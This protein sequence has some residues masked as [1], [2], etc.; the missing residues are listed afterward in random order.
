MGGDARPERCA[1]GED[2]R[3]EAHQNLAACPSTSPERR[4][5]HVAAAAD[6]GRD[7]AV[8]AGLE[9]AAA[10]FR[11]RRD[12]FEAAAAME[13][14]AERSPDPEAAAR[15]LA[16]AVSDARD[17][18][19]TRW[20]TD[21]HAAVR[22]TTADPDLIAA[23]A[24][25]AALALSRSGRQHAAYGLITAA[26]RSGPPADPVSLH[27]SS[28]SPR[29]AGSSTLARASTSSPSAVGPSAAST[30]S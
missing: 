6:A 17:L 13:Q 10:V 19:E 4:A 22:R 12:F 14:A 2:L 20:A 18:G 29:T 30:T 27:T 28:C 21:L 25:A 16:R 1:S 24:S 5:L 26:R 9:A 23:A 15:R 3:R 7:E 8:A 11:G